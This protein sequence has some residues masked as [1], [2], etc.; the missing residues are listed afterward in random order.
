M[1]YQGV[2]AKEGEIEHLTDI[3]G[4]DVVG[5]LVNAPLS[6]HSEGVRVLPMDTILPS[7]GTGVVSCVPSDSPAD[8]ITLMDLRKKAAYYGIEQAWAELDVVP[9]IDTPMG[10]LIAKTLCE[11]LKIG[12]PKDTVQLEK[13]KDTAY[14][15]G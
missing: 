15:E 6:V 3:S 7:K 11:Q 13:A 10:D 4:A 14:T 2:F 5:S 12:S 8:W 9:V 1:A